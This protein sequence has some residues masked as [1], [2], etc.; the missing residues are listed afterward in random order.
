[1]YKQR[2]PTRVATVAVA[3]AAMARVVEVGTLMVVVVVTAGAVVVV[4]M[5]AGAVVAAGGG[6]SGSGALAMGA[7][8]DTV[9]LGECEISLRELYEEK[10]AAGSNQVARLRLIR[11]RC[12]TYS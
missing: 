12:G 11:E 5:A 7:I 6:G 2:T 3:A 8:H 4:I 9:V 10:M 1:M